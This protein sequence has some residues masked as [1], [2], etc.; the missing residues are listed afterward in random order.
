[1]RVWNDHGSF[2]I[3]ARVSPAIPPGEALVYH[4]WEPYQF[5]GW[6]GNME[7]VSSPYK[8]LHLAGGYVH[9]CNRVFFGGPIHVPRGIPI[10]IEPTEGAATAQGA[11]P[12][13][14][15]GQPPLGTLAARPGEKSGL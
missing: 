15:A 5:P 13:T 3:G 7:V 11:D 12:A 14:A 9:L 8:P 6:R 10:E 2:Q 4:A 1:M